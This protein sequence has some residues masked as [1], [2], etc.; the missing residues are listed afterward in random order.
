MSWT[1]TASSTTDR[2]MSR[3][4]DYWKG[5]YV[6]ESP[7]AEIEAHLD[8]SR[9]ISKAETI[10]LVRFELSKTAPSVLIS[11]GSGGHALIFA[12]LA[13]Q[14]FRAGYNVFI[15][16]KHGGHSI[17]Q[18]VVRHETALQH[19]SANFNDRIGVYSE[20]LGGFVMFYL[21]LAR[22]PFKSGIYQNSPAL[23]TER[24][25]RNVVLPGWR[26]AWLPVLISLARVAPSMPIQISSYLNWK[27]L[28]DPDV[29]N[30]HKEAH[31]VDGFLGDPDFD[32]SY[33]A[34]AVASLLFTPPP[35][36]LSQLTIP[37]MFMISLRGF[38][39][40]AYVRYLDNLY[41]RLPV[42]TKCKRE[43]DGGAYWMLSHP[44][45]AANIICEW[46]QQTV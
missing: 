2:V 30:R 12:E 15:M 25:F 31:L 22:G 37:S 14:I 41:E 38:G 43:I 8:A 33:P 26:K 27:D 44:R 39:G 3:Y 46:F 1:I 23:L 45:Q 9:F 4:S 6:V 20:G 40:D 24:R 18:L 19:I 35:Q 32:R 10:E 5:H 28:I 11:Q 29:I 17:E 7:V 42:A 16:P 36:P 34:S 13:Y 21:A